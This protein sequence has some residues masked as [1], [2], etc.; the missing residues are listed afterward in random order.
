[1][2]DAERVVSADPTAQRDY[3]CHQVSWLLESVGDLEAAES[4]WV[5]L[6]PPTRNVFLTFEWASM[7]W[8]HF[9]QPG[10]S[11]VFACRAPNGE[12]AAILP[13]YLWRR[14]PVRVLRLVGHGPSDELGAVCSPGDSA[15]AASLIPR[16]LADVH[17][18][19]FLVAESVAASGP[20]GRLA[21]ATTM[22]RVSSPVLDFAGRT[23]DDL[24]GSFSSN[25]RQQIR[26]RERRLSR[27]HNLR[28]RLTGRRDRLDRDLDTLFRLY[29]ARWGAAAPAFSGTRREL[30]RDFAHLAHER[31]WLRLWI[32]ELDDRPA[33]AWYG[34]RFGGAEC[35]YQA[36]R[37]PSLDQHAIG[38]VLLSHT[39]RAAIED[40]MVEYRFLR[41][42]EA[43]KSRFADRDAPVETITLANGVLGSRLINLA[44]AL[45]HRPRTRQLLQRAVG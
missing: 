2:E 29:D 38:F 14:G 22:R 35:F 34:F 15:A 28:F 12:V 32:A 25:L 13:L 1:M 10:A 3:N 33:A 17:G 6:A 8:R 44:A 24:L 40:G 27:E 4:H 39:I 18:A 36:G 26:R 5:G 45:D 19:Q 11:R 9:G 23:W 31:G 20:I 42:A 30:H 21:G 43:Y 16:A 7:W 37:D 41:G